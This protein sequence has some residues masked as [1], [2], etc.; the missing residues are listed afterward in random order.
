[1]K[2]YVAVTDNEWFNYL[3]RLQPDEL[4]FWR[5][6]GGT[7]Q[8]IRQWEPLLFKLHAPQNY[9]AGG[10]FFVRYS[11]LP[12]TLAWEAF[13]E[14][15]GAPDFGTLYEQIGKYRERGGAIQPD[16]TIGCII[17]AQ[18]FFFD[19]KDWIPA[20]PDWHPN[21]VQGKTYDTEERAGAAL[22]KQVED[23]TLKLNL[24]AL[25]KEQPLPAIAEDGKRY[26]GPYPIPVRLGQ[27]AF[28]VLVTEAYARR[29]AITGERTLPVLQ[30]VH[31]KPYS[32]SGPHR[33][34]NGILLRADLHILLDR[35]YVT[36]TENLRVE[37]S[38][39]IKEDFENGEDY[40]T[41][42]GKK[43]EVIPPREIDR[44]STEF[45]RW[46]NQNRFLG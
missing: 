34:D 39:R 2:F 15:N 4:N 45:I 32:V 29:C 43:L 11:L 46:H 42:H 22:W 17:L 5:P 27:G 21:I 37:V 26:G 44:P 8:A 30:A 13:G 7:F 20:P 40:S 14:K 19:V 16:P 23:R 6:G 24:Y 38:R 9:I 3:K 28:R 33:V 1:M 31:I 35:G 41:M 12:L 10:G 36:L 18:P 25:G